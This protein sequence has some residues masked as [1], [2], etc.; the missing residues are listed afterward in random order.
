MSL[1]KIDTKRKKNRCLDHV[2]SL[3]GPAHVSLVL[4][5]HLRSIT[6]REDAVTSFS[7]VVCTLH[8][9]VSAFFLFREGGKVPALG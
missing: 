6:Y 2:K 7:H 5:T 9:V 1:L 4:T 3:V 8:P